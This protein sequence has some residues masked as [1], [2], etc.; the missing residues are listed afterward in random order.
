M[1]LAL[2]LKINWRYMRGFISGISVSILYTHIRLV[3]LLKHTSFFAILYFKKAWLF[4]IL[5]GTFQNFW[6]TQDPMWCC[7]NQFLNSHLS[8][9]LLIVSTPATL[10]A[11]YNTEHSLYFH[12]VCF[13]SCN[14]LSRKSPPSDFSRWRCRRPARWSPP[15]TSCVKLSLTSSCIVDC[16]PFCVFAELVYTWSLTVILEYQK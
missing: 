5:S 15:T 9:P 12:T 16:F 8:P 2:F 3:L 1:V 13:H 4:S 7:F 6:H 10:H 11:A 14:F